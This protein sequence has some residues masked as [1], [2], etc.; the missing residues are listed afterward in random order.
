MESNAPAVD[1]EFT[2]QRRKC[3]YRKQECA[4]SLFTSPYELSEPE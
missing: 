2:Q 1:V 3:M 4:T